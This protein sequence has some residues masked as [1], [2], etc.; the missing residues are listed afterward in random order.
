MK[1]LKDKYKD[2][3]QGGDNAGADNGGGLIF[4]D[5]SGDTLEVEGEP[6]AKG[7]GVTLFIKYSRDPEQWDKLY[8]S[9]LSNL[10][11]KASSTNRTIQMDFNNN[12]FMTTK[13]QVLDF[14]EIHQWKPVENCRYASVAS[15]R[16]IR[17]DRMRLK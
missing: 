2:Y 6:S 7:D 17:T 12:G 9:H 15:E 3:Q 14:L 5:A 10:E 13:E 1:T 8:Q 16:R 11:N 4:Q